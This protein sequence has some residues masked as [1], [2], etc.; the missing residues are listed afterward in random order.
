MDLGLGELEGDH[1]TSWRRGSGTLAKGRGGREVWGRGT[2]GWGLN[3]LP[4]SAA[5]GKRIAEGKGPAAVGTQGRGGGRR[6]TRRAA[7]GGP[8]EHM[9]RAANPLPCGENKNQGEAGGGALTRRADRSMSSR[10]RA[11]AGSPMA[12]AGNGAPGPLTLLLGYSAAAVATSPPSGDPR[13]GH[14]GGGGGPAGRPTH[15]LTAAIAREPATRAS[16]LSCAGAEWRRAG[17]VDERT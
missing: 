9:R 1:Q 12:S 5:S 4:E 7:R 8:G 6:G 14:H 2:Q 11:G 10:L 16:R 17:R 15:G 3:W 13:D